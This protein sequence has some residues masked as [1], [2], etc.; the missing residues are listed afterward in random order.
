MA[1]DTDLILGVSYLGVQDFKDR[2]SLFGAGGTVGQLSDPEILAMLAGASRAV[3]GYCGRSFDPTQSITENHAW[4]FKNKRVFPNQPPLTSLTSYR[5]RQGANYFSTF[6]V[7]PVSN[8]TFGEIYYNPQENYLEL[9]SL[10][11]ALALNAQLLGLGLKEPQVEITYT[12]YTSVPQGVL[13]AVGLTAAA[14][15]N[16]NA[17]SKIL[18]TGI[19]RIEIDGQKI[20]KEQAGPGMTLPIAIQLTQEAKDYLD[21]YNRLYIY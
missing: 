6:A 10:A 7:S 2:A 11:A 18:P 21:Q 19:R 8:T 16:R 20:E 17:T 14:A 1:L 3:D 5:I 12:S 4:D 13:M 15:A 9:A